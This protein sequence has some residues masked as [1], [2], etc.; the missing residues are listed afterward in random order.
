MTPAG[1]HVLRV[2]QAVPRLHER[3]MVRVRPG[4]QPGEKPVFLFRDDFR[5]GTQTAE[6]YPLNLMLVHGPA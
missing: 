4:D 6:A 5:R 3:G 2:T 1:H